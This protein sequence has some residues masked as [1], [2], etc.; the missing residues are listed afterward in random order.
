MCGGECTY[1][2]VLLYQTPSVISGHLYTKAA[3]FMVLS[4]SD[5]LSNWGGVEREGLR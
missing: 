3:I 1:C 4:F 5:V 2:G